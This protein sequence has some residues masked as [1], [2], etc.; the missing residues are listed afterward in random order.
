MPSALIIQRMNRTIEYENEEKGSVGVPLD[1]GYKE[2]YLLVAWFLS[3][4]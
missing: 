1:A 3:P 4:S 2:L